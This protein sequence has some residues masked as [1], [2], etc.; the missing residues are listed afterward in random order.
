MNNI[1]GAS[2]LL[3]I[4]A[5]VFICGY[6]G[7][8]VGDLLK[9]LKNHVLGEAPVDSQT[10]EPLAAK[11]EIP[12]KKPLAPPVGAPKRQNRKANNEAAPFYQMLQK[13][14]QNPA[15]PSAPNAKPSQVAKPQN[16][17]GSMKETLSSINRDSIDK[18][19]RLRRNDYFNKLS[20]Q[21]EQMRGK[22]PQDD[23]PEVDRDTNSVQANIESE[24]NVAE[25]AD[26]EDYEINEPELLNESVESIDELDDAIDEL[27]EGPDA[28]LD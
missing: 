25:D 6:R 11:Q 14:R 9:S 5:V 22:K 2:L 18:D 20:E 19:Q 8:S 26:L 16:W 10:G 3:S 15:R 24:E 4:F 17:Q 21:M 27:L 7:E 13:Q 12:A 23:S 28:V 1:R